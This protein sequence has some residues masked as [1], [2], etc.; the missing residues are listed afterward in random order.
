MNTEEVL[1]RA[2]HDH[3]ED[4]LAWRA[5]ADALEE[6]GQPDR[7]ELLRLD[8]TLRQATG[9]TER[10]QGQGPTRRQREQSLMRLLAE[11]ARPSLPVLTNPVGMQLVL[12]PPGS[13]FMGSPARE[14]GRFAQEGPCHKVMVPRAFYL[15]AH[16][17]TQAQWRAV[18]GGN[19]SHFPG[20]N[21]PVE[22]VS[23]DDCQE[24][25]RELGSIDGR[26]YRLP[27]EAEW[28][29]AC[30]A[31]TT[32]AFHG[33][34]T[35]RSLRGVGWCSYNK[36]FAQAGGTRPVGSLLPN[37][38]GLYDMHGNVRE[39]CIGWCGPY[40]EAE[41]TGPPHEDSGETRCWRG[42][43]WADL[44]NYCRSAYRNNH[45]PPGRRCEYIGLRVCCEVG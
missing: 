10:W 43:S 27:S 13:F 28:E 22:M 14:R 7:A 40:T 16:P 39:W 31:C 12:V 30:R 1:F 11:G 33:G 20:D 15:G 2:I 8:L 17:V 25:C 19:P 6:Q 34:D 18:L 44:W 38:W 35:L 42:G 26:S 23:W 3:P 37:A 5:L 4:E 9:P 32:T 45:D 36:R 41:V 21:H 29:Y 24:F